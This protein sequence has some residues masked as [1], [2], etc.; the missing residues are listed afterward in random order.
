MHTRGVT[1]ARA[2]LLSAA[3]V[4][5]AALVLGGCGGSDEKDIR[6]VVKTSQRLEDRSRVCGLM[7]P[8]AQA[9]A[10]AL[11]GGGS[12]ARLELERD[13]DAP[14]NSE[15]DKASLKVRGDRAVLSFG[16][17]DPDLGLRK[18]D[19]RWLIDNTINASLDEKPRRYDDAVA[20]GSD[21]QQ[22]RAVLKANAA[23]F[24][25]GDYTRA[26]DLLSYGAEAQIFAGAVFAA[27]ADPKA[28]PPKGASCAAVIRIVEK[29][30]GAKD[31]F[32]ENVL[33]AGQIDAAKIAIRGDR[34]A[35]SVGDDLHLAVRQEGHWLVG[36]DP[37]GLASDE[38]PTAAE[39][40]LERCWRRAG[41]SIA[42]TAR[43]LRFA[44]GDR[45]RALSVNDGHISI[46]GADWRIFYTESRGSDTPRFERV[47]HKSILSKP[48]TARA[49]AYVRDARAHPRVV[50][51]ARDCGGPLKYTLKPVG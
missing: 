14:T 34:A 23:A 50:A 30:A 5:V 19:G 33:T 43:D 42:T 20:K 40:D 44:V 8:R 47:L 38:P 28:A 29:A 45:V 11:F 49:V 24:A 51:R 48:R 16:G 31:A 36:P 21:E 35:V 46:K 7:T 25:K 1:H 13:E 18:V 17:E 22:V 3:A 10:T 15:I 12:C 32:S 26:C 27:S 2:S 6:E 9:Q 39:P 37:E 41:A 4:A